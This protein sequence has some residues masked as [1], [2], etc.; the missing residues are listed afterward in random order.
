MTHT[1]HLQQSQAGRVPAAAWAELKGGVRVHFIEDKLKVLKEHLGFRDQV[2]VDSG[3]MAIRRG[4]QCGD[5]LEEALCLGWGSIRRAGAGAGQ[6]VG[7][8]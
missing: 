8:W 5:K 1:L 7:P 3:T 2:W 6:Q 4:R